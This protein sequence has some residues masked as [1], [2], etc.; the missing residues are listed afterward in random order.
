ML[1]SRLKLPENSHPLGSLQWASLLLAWDNSKV[2]ASYHVQESACKVKLHLPTVVIGLDNMPPIGCSPSVSLPHSSIRV[3]FN[4]QINFLRLN[5]CFRICFWGDLRYSSFPA[6][7]LLLFLGTAISMTTPPTHPVIQFRKSCVSH[8]NCSLH[9]PSL[10]PVDSICPEYHLTQVPTLHLCWH[11]LDSNSDHCHSLSLS[12]AW[13]PC[14]QSH[15]PIS[16]SHPLERSFLDPNLSWSLTP[17]LQVFQCS[18]LTTRKSSFTGQTR[19]LNWPLASSASPNAIH[20]STPPSQNISSLQEVFCIQT[21]VTAVLFICNSFP[22]LWKTSI[23][24]SVLSSCHHFL[25]IFSDCPAPCHSLSFPNTRI[26]PQIQC[27]PGPFCNSCTTSCHI[28]SLTFYLLAYELLGVSN[29]VLTISLTIVLSSVTGTHQVL[30]RCLL[31][32]SINHPSG[33]HVKTRVCGDAVLGKQDKDKRIRSEMGNLLSLYFKSTNIRITDLKNHPEQQRFFSCCL[34]M[35]FLPSIFLGSPLTVGIQLFHVLFLSEN[36]SPHQIQTF[37][38]WTPLF[39]FS[40]Q[41]QSRRKYRRVPPYISLGM[42]AMMPIYYALIW[43]NI[44]F[45]ENTSTSKGSKYESQLP[46]RIKH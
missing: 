14:C 34:G 27:L 11:Y 22:L 39:P 46:V 41:E 13:S 43:I 1:G 25:A 16:P 40:L 4:F 30:N 18:L 3:F 37:S 19:D 5:P 24:L 29:P 26:E 10:S 8:P 38:L 23:H 17:F 31:N 35:S 44:D 21:L 33:K 2:S 9:P 45:P 7:N 42:G 32:K 20:S 28:V 6:P 12:L 15:S 36:I